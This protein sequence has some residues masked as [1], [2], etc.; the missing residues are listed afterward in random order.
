MLTAFGLHSIQLELW[1]I[2]LLVEQ[3][4][5]ETRPCW[6]PPRVCFLTHTCIHKHA[7]GLRGVRGSVAWIVWSP[8]RVRKKNQRFLTWILLHPT[9]SG[10]PSP[11]LFPYHHHH[12]TAETKKIQTTSNGGFFVIYSV[13]SLS[14]GPQHNQEGLSQKAK[15]NTEENQRYQRLQPMDLGTREGLVPTIFAKKK[16]CIRIYSCGRKR[17]RGWVGRGIIIKQKR[18]L[19]TFLIQNF[20]EG[21]K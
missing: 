11:L 9:L 4:P 15:R 18:V 5:E 10:A 1:N 21:Q 6:F 14:P 20:I 12:L 8:C 13:S 17:N 3:Q 16:S 7:K 2:L 19:G